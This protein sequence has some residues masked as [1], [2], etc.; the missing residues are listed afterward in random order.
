[1]SIGALAD[2][3]LEQVRA[4]EKTAS[5]P[6]NA[7]ATAKPEPVPS[8]ST[9]EALRKVAQELR[10]IGESEKVTVSDLEAFIRS[11]K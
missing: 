4:E 7:S 2:E 6:A 1:M 11:G 3:L 10:R 5:A 9:G 8:T